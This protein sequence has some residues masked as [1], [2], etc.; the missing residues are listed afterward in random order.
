MNSENMKNLYLVKQKDSE[1]IQAVPVV[2]KYQF[3]ISN[4]LFLPHDHVVNNPIESD[5]IK[6]IVANHLCTV[7]SWRADGASAKH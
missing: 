5:N 4:H 2:E 3:D 7:N 6:S 1:E